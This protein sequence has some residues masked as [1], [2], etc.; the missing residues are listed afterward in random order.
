MPEKFLKEPV[1]NGPCKGS[2]IN[3]EPMLKEFYSLMGW[4]KDGAV[5]KE[6]LKE[7]GLDEV[8]NIKNNVL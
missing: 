5:S 4:E 3:L 7:L 1:Q 2:V 8:L 6:K